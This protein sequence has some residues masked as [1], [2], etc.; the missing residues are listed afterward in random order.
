MDTTCLISLLLSFRENGIES[1][2]WI[3]RLLCFSL[4]V[5]FFLYSYLRKKEAIFIFVEACEDARHIDY[6]ER[7]YH[8]QYKAK[9]LLRINFRGGLFFVLYDQ[10]KKTCLCNKKYCQFL[11]QM[12][13]Y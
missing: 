1:R 10:I 9:S 4:A 5:V 8:I 2:A 11:I 7:T 13:N 12:M 6:D 3:E